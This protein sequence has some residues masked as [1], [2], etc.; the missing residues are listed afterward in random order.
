MRY[1][2]VHIERGRFRVSDMKGTRRPHLVDIVANF[3]EGKCECEAYQIRHISPCKH[4]KMVHEYLGRQVAK[5]LQ[6]QYGDGDEE[7]QI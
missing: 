6:E 1:K 5:N 2:I 4:I 3:A 7:R